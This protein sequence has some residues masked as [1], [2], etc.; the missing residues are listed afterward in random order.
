MNS[1][2]SELPI[3]PE[4][5]SGAE[6]PASPPRTA[7]DPTRLIYLTAL[8]VVLSLVLMFA[9]P[10]WQWLWPFASVIMAATVV[11]V[12]ISAWKV[13]DFLTIPPHKS[14]FWSRSYNSEIVRRFYIPLALRLISVIIFMSYSGIIS[15]WFLRTRGWDSFSI[16]VSYGLSSSLVFLFVALM[17]GREGS[18]VDRVMLHRPVVLVAGLLVFGATTALSFNST[19]I[20][21]HLK[22]GPAAPWSA[23]WDLVRN[24]VEAH[25]PGSV[26]V[27]LSAGRDFDTPEDYNSPLRLA[28]LFWHAD[29]TTAYVR[30]LDTTPESTIEYTWGGADAN[31]ARNTKPQEELDALKAVYPYI[32][33]SPRDALNAA[34]AHLGSE[35]P[36]VGDSG[37]RI[38]LEMTD[39]SP[40]LSDSF[41]SLHK[42]AAWVVTLPKP[43]YGLIT[44]WVD[45][46]TGRVLL[47]EQPK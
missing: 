44:V 18:F 19:A 26:L 36:P 43:N 16:Y 38:R 31:G 24:E 37:P 39:T 15:A 40:S 1:I 8:G 7:A 46:E 13:E 5:P 47:V 4:I 28:F 27:S 41:S 25:Y 45:A 29:G 17:W 12:Y 32:L 22:V 21:G 42:P 11:G 20:I 33:T 23:Q 10:T 14:G 3:S 30:L 35:A 2:S 9:V 34:L 6:A